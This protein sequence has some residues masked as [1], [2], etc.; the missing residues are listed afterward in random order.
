M[1]RRAAGR[2]L[3]SLGKLQDAAEDL[4]VFRGRKCVEGL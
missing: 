1:R 4:R 2:L 3:S